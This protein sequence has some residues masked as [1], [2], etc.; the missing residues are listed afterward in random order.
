[1]KLKGTRESYYHYTGKTSDIIRYLG[2]AGIGIIWIFRVEGIG[3]TS[4][5][6]NLLFPTVLM[7]IGLGFDLLQYLTAS[8]VWGVYSRHKEK[9]GTEENEEFDAPRQINWLTNIF[10]GLKI[11]P[12][13]WAYILILKYL[14]H[15]LF[16]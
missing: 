6:Q 1:M 8:V 15:L 13:V 5:P 11:I 2:L 14:S 3:K 9:S 12:I 16:K 10:F 7:I 4:L